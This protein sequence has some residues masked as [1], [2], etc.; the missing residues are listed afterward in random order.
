MTH[1]HFHKCDLEFSSGQVNRPSCSHS[2]VW[3][4]SS[5]S[6]LVVFLK[7]SSCLCLTACRFPVLFITSTASLSLSETICHVQV[8]WLN[9][10]PT[11]LCSYYVDRGARRNYVSCASPG[12]VSH[13]RLVARGRL[14]PGVMT[15]VSTTVPRPPGVCMC[16]CVC[17]C[18]YGSLCVVWLEHTT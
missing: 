6:S 5:Y 13:F 4:G 14:W 18:G 3:A 11:Y 7:I 9:A 1:Q 8:G 17:V 16:E 15:N 2:Q 10:L 12:I